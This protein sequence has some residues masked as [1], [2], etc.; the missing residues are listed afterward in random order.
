MLGNNLTKDNDMEVVPTNEW[1]APMPGRWQPTAGSGVPSWDKSVLKEGPEVGN[2]CKNMVQ[3]YRHWG[4]SQQE[5]MRKRLKR[6]R[7]LSSQRLVFDDYLSQQFDYDL[8]YMS[9]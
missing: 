7:S 9:F 3:I 5:D 1:E 2:L 4:G 8:V 6:V